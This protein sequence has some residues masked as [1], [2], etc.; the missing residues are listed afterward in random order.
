M[1]SSKLCIIILNW[2]SIEDTLKAVGLLH[3]SPW[4][5]CVVDNGSQNAGEVALLRETYS[6]VHVVET[7]DNL[8]YAGG[9]NTGMRWAA[10]QGFTHSL[11]LNP[12]TTPSIDVVEGMLRLSDGCAVVGT[13]QVTE[14]HIPYVSAAILQG[15]KK[16]I[17]FRCPAN[18]GNGHDV[19]IVSGAGM[20]IELDAA[21]ALGYMDERFFHYKE[22]FDFCFR[23]T[24]S[25]G[26]IR[27]NC[28]SPLIHRCGGS[29]AS[30]SASGMY[31]TFRNEV[32]FLRKHFGLLASI[33]GIGIY[34]NA[35]KSMIDEPKNSAAILRGILH[36]VQGITGPLSKLRPRGI[37]K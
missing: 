21:A 17:P 18:C 33:S 26:R 30:S 32:L 6:D 35:L 37:T 14:D 22:E 8:G 19:D 36:G 24:S 5:I 11:L 16:V 23:V 1:N 12:D 34:R 15:K 13:V 27:F 3:A 10:S 7:G 9:M 20:L 31:Y 25:G 4:D 2:N 28:G 29:L